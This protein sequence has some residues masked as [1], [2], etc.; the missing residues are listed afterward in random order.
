MTEAENMYE[1]AL[2]LGVPETSMI[3]ENNSQN[4]KIYYVPFWNYSVPCGLI[5]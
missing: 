4:K 2:E 3:L 5:E 1:K